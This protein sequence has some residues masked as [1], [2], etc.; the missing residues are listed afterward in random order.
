MYLKESYVYAYLREDGSPYYIGKGKGSRYRKKHTVKVPPKERIEFIKTGL[1]DDEA[2]ALEIELIAKYGRK[3]IGTGILR[4]Q[5]D[6]GDGGRNVGPAVRKKIS[7]ANKGCTP[8]NKGVT[9]WKCNPDGFENRSR[10]KAG[11]KHPMYGKHH[12]DEARQKIA[13]GIKANWSR[14]TLTCPHCGKEGKVGMTRWH[15]DNCKHR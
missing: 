7:E 5:T 10:A 11:E 8:W 1:S 14:P 9:G 15:F 13:E 2:V 6:G 3:D 12:T 4:N